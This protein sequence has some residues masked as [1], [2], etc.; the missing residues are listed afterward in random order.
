MKLDFDILPSL[1]QSIVSRDPLLLTGFDEIALNRQREL[2]LTSGFAYGN[3]AAH[4]PPKG[5]PISWTYSHLGLNDPG[6]RLYGFSK[7]TALWQRAKE[8]YT[9]DDC[10]W[11]LNDLLAYLQSQSEK[12][13]N[14]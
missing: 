14:A 10:S 8:V 2:L 4:K 13:P 1:L 11:S 7:D 6:E 3:S 12:T 9:F 5:Q